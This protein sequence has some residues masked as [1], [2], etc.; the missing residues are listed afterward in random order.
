MNL[1]QAQATIN[2]LS[3]ENKE[4]TEKITTLEIQVRKLLEAVRGNKSEKQDPHELLDGCLEFFSEEELALL[5]SEV[6]STEDDEDEQPRPKRRKK[7]R[8]TAH[9][10]VREK[11]IL[12]EAEECRCPNCEAEMDR[13]WFETVEK[14]GFQ[15]AA[16]YVVRYLLETRAC[17]CGLLPHND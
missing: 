4:L 9:L 12:L 17:S 10:E 8:S 5:E 6:V 13:S 11:K 15:P 7:Q 14:F 16:F 3:Q 2:E 1:T